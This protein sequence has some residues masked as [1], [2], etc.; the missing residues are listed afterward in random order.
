MLFTDTVKEKT[1]NEKRNKNGV[2]VNVNYVFP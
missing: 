1:K 2:F